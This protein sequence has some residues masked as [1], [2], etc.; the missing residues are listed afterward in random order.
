M[1]LGGIDVDKPLTRDEL[2][3]LSDAVRGV[4][5]DA[6]ERANLAR[7]FG[8]GGR[9]VERWFTTAAQRRNIAGVTWAGQ[10]L[11][12]MPDARAQRVV[13]ALLLRGEVTQT[14][15]G[16]GKVESYKVRFA[17]VADAARYVTDLL[18]GGIDPYLSKVWHRVGMVS[19]EGGYTL[20]IEYR[21][22]SFAY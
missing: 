4:A 1:L 5:L 13:A 22:D 6:G 8:V 15:A 16:V 14:T 10:S 18:K 17:T 21:R 20:K 2:R 3:A 19:E 12:Q 7:S 11:R 9:T